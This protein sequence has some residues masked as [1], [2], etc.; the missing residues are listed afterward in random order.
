MHCSEGE[1]VKVLSVKPEATG[2]EV[3]RGSDW[4]RRLGGRRRANVRWTVKVRSAVQGDLAESRGDSKWVLMRGRRGG[5]RRWCQ[6][7][8]LTGATGAEGDNV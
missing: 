3:Q 6:Q 8:G 2:C 1:T 7:H 4:M 5:E